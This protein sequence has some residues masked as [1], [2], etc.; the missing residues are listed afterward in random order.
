MSARDF[1]LLACFF[2]MFLALCCAIA[3][4]PL[5]VSVGYF[6]GSLFVAV[7]VANDPDFD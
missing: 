3:G 4:V 1:I 6:V 7:W 5:L 2:A